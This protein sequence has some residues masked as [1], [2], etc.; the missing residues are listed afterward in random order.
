M[1]K[2]MFKKVDIETKM[3]EIEE[4]ISRLEKRYAVGLE[5]SMQFSDLSVRQF[6]QDPGTN[7]ILAKI[8]KLNK[9]WQ[10]LEDS[11]PKM[12]S[13]FKK[14]NDAP[15][16][17]SEEDRSRYRAVMSKL[18]DEEFEA[19]LLYVRWTPEQIEGLYAKYYNCQMSVLCKSFDFKETEEGGKFWSAIADRI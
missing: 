10:A 15:S 1:T 7:G 19:Y 2:N 14:R 5:N 16:V 18:T 17:M 3:F 8:Q 12:T 11:K 9:E 6:E 13:P 4:E